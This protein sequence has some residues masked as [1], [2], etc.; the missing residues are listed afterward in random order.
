MEE[1][2]VYLHIC[3]LCIVMGRWVEE[4][5]F[6]SGSVKIN[7]ICK[8]P[9]SMPNNMQEKPPRHSISACP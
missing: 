9:L 5:R 7:V 3:I 1:E 4:F 8:I 6:H 2:H